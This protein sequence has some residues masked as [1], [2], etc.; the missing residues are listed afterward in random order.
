MA[1][2]R[3]S[4][5]G[6]RRASATTSL[7]L[8]CLVGCNGDLIN[9]GSSEPLV[10]GG[11][12]GSS[13]AGAS[14]GGAVQGGGGSSEWIASAEPVLSLEGYVVANPTLTSAGV[15]FLSIL[16]R[17]ESDPHVY[18]AEASGDRFATPNP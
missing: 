7:A 11:E 4:S 15:M 12:A 1:R 17:G 3:L 18:L 8:S 14:G 13:S 9:L 6:V 16:P 5:P 10:V 2:S